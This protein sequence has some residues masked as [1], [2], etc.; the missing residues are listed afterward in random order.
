MTM[1]CR[2]PWEVIQSIVA[3]SR[4][5][6]QSQRTLPWEGVL[7]RIARWPIAYFGVVVRE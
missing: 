4:R 2:P 7:I 5:V 6:R 1:A 3:A